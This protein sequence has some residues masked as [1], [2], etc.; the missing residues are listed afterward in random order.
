MVKQLRKKLMDTKRDNPSFQLGQ[1][2]CSVINIFHK[3]MILKMVK[4][5]IY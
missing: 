2:L 1:V 5:L 4:Q 3:N